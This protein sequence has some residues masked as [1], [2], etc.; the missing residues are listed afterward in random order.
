MI[1]GPDGGVTAHQWSVGAG[2]WMN[3][4]T[5]VDAVGSSGRKRDYL[6]K[7]YDYVFDVDIEDGKP[8]LK[9]PYNLSENPYEAATK[10]IQKNELP[11]TYLDQVANFITSNT[12]GATIGQSQPAQPPGADPW[13]T[14]ARYRPGDASSAPSASPP[15]AS[16]PKILP[17]TTY[18]SIKQANLKTIQKKLE[19]LNQQLISDGNKDASLNPS[20]LRILETLVAHLEQAP[21]AAAKPSP[22]VTNGLELVLRIIIEWPSARRLPGIDLLRL[23]AFAT[24]ATATYRTARGETVVDVLE[25]SGIFRDRDRSNNIMLAI[26]TFANLFETDQGRS[27]ADESFEKVFASH[28]GHQGP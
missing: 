21:T 15:S 14:E 26:R 7:D 22:A 24:P 12:Q 11:M 28:P 3:V 10:F 19:E 25:R 8:P 23:L 16:I 27:L 6:G 17:Q 9:L 13:G 4:G 18:L 2:Q 1:R 20:D 5:V